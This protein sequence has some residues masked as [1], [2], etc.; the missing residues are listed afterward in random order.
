L[1]MIFGGSRQTI[2]ARPSPS[3]A[4]AGLPKPSE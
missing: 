1:N 3:Q 2:G 4:F